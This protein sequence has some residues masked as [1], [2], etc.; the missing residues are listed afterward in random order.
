M[1]DKYE[2]LDGY[3][4]MATKLQDGVYNN[5]LPY[6][7]ETRMDYRKKDSEILSQF[8]EDMYEAFG[9]EDN[10][11]RELCYSLAWDRGHSHGLNEVL[12]HFSEFVN[13][14]K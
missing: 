7:K 5:P 14:I 13:L 9:V 4:L 2:Y 12:I 3:E 8:Q 6:T 11:K 1:G 10:P